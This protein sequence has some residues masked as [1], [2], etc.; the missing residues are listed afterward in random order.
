VKLLNKNALLARIPIGIR[1]L[2]LQEA[3]VSAESIGTMICRQ[4]NP[5]FIARVP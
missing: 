2:D 4:M 1:L 5:P 3:L